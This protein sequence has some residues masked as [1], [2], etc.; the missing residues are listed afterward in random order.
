MKYQWNM[1]SGV[2]PNVGAFNRG[3]VLSDEDAAKLLALGYEL[4]EVKSK[5]QQPKEGEES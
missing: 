5:K 3:D 4:V 2:V 1:D